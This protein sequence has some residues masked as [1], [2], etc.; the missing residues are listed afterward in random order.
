MSAPQV[1]PADVEAAIASEH[2]FTA[3][4]GVIGA[5]AAGEFDSHGS[6]VVILR[7]DIASTEVM[8]PSLNLLTFC[9]LVLKN[10]HIVSGEAYCADPAKFNAETGRI[11]ARKAAIN[12]L[13]PMVV[14][15][16]RERLA[17]KSLCFLPLVRSATPEQLAELREAMRDAHSMPMILEPDTGITWTV[18]DDDDP[19]TL[20]P[21]AG[22]YLVTVETDSGRETH[23]LAHTAYGKWMHEGEFTFQHDYYFRPIAWAPRPEAYAGEVPE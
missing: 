17:A 12:K 2:Y 6:D 3:G 13:W 23:V 16:E 18:L 1:T 19:T 7:R 22:D 20:P 5:F 9:V 10:G 11:E 14:Y 21:A 4:E 8:K 15:A